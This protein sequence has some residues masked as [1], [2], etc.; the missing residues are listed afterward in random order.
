MGWLMGIVVMVVVVVLLLVVLM[1]DIRRALSMVDSRAVGYLVRTNMLYVWR[2]VGLR[3]N[4]VVRVVPQ[5]GIVEGAAG[6]RKFD[7]F[8]EHLLEPNRDMMNNV[9][10]AGSFLLQHGDDAPYL[11][12][13][14]LSAHRGK[15]DTSPTSS[16]LQEEYGSK[17][18]HRGD[19]EGDTNEGVADVGVFQNYGKH[20]EG[21]VHGDVGMLSAER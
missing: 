5:S 8:S 14:L 6:I 18:D 1:M 15:P 2:L 13:H 11:I 7:A 20:R 16:H 21:R 19:I 17:G 4:R 9:L 3:G 10:L 12:P